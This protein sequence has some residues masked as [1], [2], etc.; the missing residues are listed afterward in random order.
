MFENTSASGGRELHLTRERG[1]KPN[2]VSKVRE[3]EIE[4]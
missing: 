3:T 4:I 2:T 1:M